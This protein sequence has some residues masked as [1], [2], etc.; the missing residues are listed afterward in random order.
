MYACVVCLICEVSGCRAWLS[1]S[2]IYVGS[3]PAFRL[4]YFPTTVIYSIIFESKSLLIKSD[5]VP[6][7]CWMTEN[8][9]E[10]VVYVVFLGSLFILHVI[11]FYMLVKRVQREVAGSPKK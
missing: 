1:S 3:I 9:L 5:C 10:R 7:E 4:W 8:P 2:L 11:W 6:G